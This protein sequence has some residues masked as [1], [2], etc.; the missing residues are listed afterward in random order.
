LSPIYASPFDDLGYDVEDY[1]SVAPR[2]GSLETFDRLLEAAHARNIRV[3]LDWVPNHTSDRHPWFVESRS[4][5]DS[6]KRPWY[7]WRD[8]RGDGEP[9]NNWQS[10]FGGSVW[11]WDE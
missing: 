5:R 11:E 4:S 3:I 9:P 6:A 1:C 8:A 2:F 10:V 7:F